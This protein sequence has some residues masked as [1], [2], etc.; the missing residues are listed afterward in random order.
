MMRAAM[1]ALALVAGQAAADPLGSYP[2]NADGVTVLTDA[3]TGCAA[4]MMRAEARDA[5][6]NLRQTGCYGVHNEVTVV[7]LWTGKR[8]PAT[9]VPVHLVTWSDGAQERVVK[10]GLT[11]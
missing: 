11:T 10:K 3:T 7:I 9:V 5:V 8:V 4:P 6:G 1:L 2:N